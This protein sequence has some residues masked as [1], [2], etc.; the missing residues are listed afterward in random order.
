MSRQPNDAR[1]HEYGLEEIFLDLHNGRVFF[2]FKNLM[3]DM[4]YV[5]DPNITK[6]TKEKEVES[7]KEKVEGHQKVMGTWTQ[8]A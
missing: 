6:N 1:N 4:Q 3:N 8:K 7:P 2:F 5:R